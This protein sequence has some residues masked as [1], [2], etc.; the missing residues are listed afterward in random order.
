MLEIVYSWRGRVHLLWTGGGDSSITFTLV[1]CRA[2]R[3]DKAKTFSAA[4]EALYAG[5]T[6]MGM[7]ARFELVL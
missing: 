2:V 6:V 7:M 4:L 5:A 3:R 1:F